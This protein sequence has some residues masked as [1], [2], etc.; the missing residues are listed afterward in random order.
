MST[1]ERLDSF[2]LSNGADDK[3]EKL[4]DLSLH[5]SSVCEGVQQLEDAPVRREE[6]A[7]ACTGRGNACD[8]LEGPMGVYRVL[9]FVLAKMENVR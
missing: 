5:S 1:E 8:C 4:E 2:P 7:T 9:N 3:F 6:H